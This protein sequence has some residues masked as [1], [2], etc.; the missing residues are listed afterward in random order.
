MSQVINEERVTS[1]LSLSYLHTRK[2]NN[3]TL[4]KVEK[5]KKVGEYTNTE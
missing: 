3:V 1:T 5:V 2:K 4:Q